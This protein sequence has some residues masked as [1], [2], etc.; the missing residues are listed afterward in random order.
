MTKTY[1]I[2]G[3]KYISHFGQFPKAE[4]F[5]RVHAVIVT[6]DGRIL[7]RIKDGSIRG[8]TGG[9][10]DVADSDVESALRR[11]IREEIN[12]EIDLWDYIGYL[13]VIEPDGHREIWAR[14]VARLAEVLPPKA[15]PDRAGAWVYGRV[16]AP[17]QIALD[18][19]TKDFPLNQEQI[20]VALEVAREKAYFTELPNSEYEVLNTE[21]RELD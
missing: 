2:D 14:V 13:E 4:K 18:E 3:A 7:L 12:C 9:H 6:R 15:D 10:I 21:N 1:D 5:D 20:Q 11:E 8:T 19:A 17:A 16:L